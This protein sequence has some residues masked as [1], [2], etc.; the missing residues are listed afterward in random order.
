VI[1]TRD[2]PCCPA[3]R[4]GATV[5]KIELR[6]ADIA[7]TEDLEK[8]VVTGVDWAVRAGEFWVIS[9]STWSGKSRLLE[10][11][12][13]L[14]PP[15]RGEY[16]LFGQ[17]LAKLPTDTAAALRRRVG[18]VFP[19]GGRLF[20]R[21]TVAQNIGLPICYH[22][23]C[24]LDAAAPRVA[25]LLAE[26]GLVTY[27]NWSPMRL[28]RSYRQ[29]IA[30]AR[31]LAME[32]EV[33]LLDNPFSGLDVGHFAW[34]LEFL[35]ALLSGH[36]ILGDKQISVVVATDDVRPWRSVANRFATI[37]DSRWMLLDATSD[38]APGGNPGFS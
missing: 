25:Q 34:W 2:Q 31:A 1:G 16:L 32:P 35:G 14:T 7:S 5:A 36:P 37:K 3:G 38:T 17:P 28:N 12:A 19:D 26:M 20:P 15:I 6:G 13:G 30:L 33:L 23:E 21:L 10:T 9:G 4:P 29:R 24:T 27:A 18:L 11:A 8:A 22:R